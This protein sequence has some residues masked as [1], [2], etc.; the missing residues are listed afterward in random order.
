VQGLSGLL[1]EKCRSRRLLELRVGDLIIH[2]SVGRV[3]LID[4]EG[5]PS[6]EFSS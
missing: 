5:V 4:V 2:G 6:Y 3:V 1:R